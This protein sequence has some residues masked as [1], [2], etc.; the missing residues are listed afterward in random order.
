[1]KKHARVIGAGLVLICTIVNICITIARYGDTFTA[2]PL[3]LFVALDAI[4]W[5]VV[6]V[7]VLIAASWIEKL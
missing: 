2:A 3:S 1:M 7:L 6:L 4:I 5:S